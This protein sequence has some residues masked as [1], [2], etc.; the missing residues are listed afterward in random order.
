MILKVFGPC[1]GILLMILPPK[2]SATAISCPRPRGDQEWNKAEGRRYFGLGNTMFKAE[3]YTEAALAFECVLTLVPYSMNSRHRLAESHEKAGELEKAL[4]QYRLALADD[5]PEAEALRPELQ[6]KVDELEARV[7]R[8]ESSPVGTAAPQM[9]PGPRMGKPAPRIIPGLI[10][11]FPDR[12]HRLDVHLGLNTSASS[13]PAI[14]LG[15]YWR[16]NPRVSWGAHVGTLGLGLTA[17]SGAA[18]TGRGYFVLPSAEFIYA[19]LGGLFHIVFGGGLGYIFAQLEDTQKVTADAHTG[20][21][22]LFMALDYR[23]NALL[24]VRFS[25]RYHYILGMTGPGDESLDRSIIGL[26]ELGLIYRF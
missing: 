24:C 18:I 21:A 6:K 12:R 8:G 17:P 11:D 25:L 15:Y 9:I 19:Q 10:E 22:S 2:V 14:F 5:S 26:Y 4:E 3:K 20:F 23:I 1:L 13:D 16:Q 7:A